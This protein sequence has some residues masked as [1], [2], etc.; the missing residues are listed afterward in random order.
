MGFLL[1]G[2]ERK[3]GS[4]EPEHRDMCH[5][6]IMTWAEET[7][8]LS[9]HKV[10]RTKVKAS[11]QYLKRSTKGFCRSLRGRIGAVK[12]VTGNLRRSTPYTHDGTS[13]TLT[14]P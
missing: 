9:Q 8:E 14:H 5:V 4:K 11:V 1:K 7:V 12:R 2:K 3:R 10:R 6:S 13:L